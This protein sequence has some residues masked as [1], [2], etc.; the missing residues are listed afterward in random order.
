[1]TPLVW[2]ELTSWHESTKMEWVV[3]W[4]L[5][6]VVVVW[7]R[8]WQKKTQV[9]SYEEI[10]SHILSHAATKKELSE[11]NGKID[12]AIIGS[13]V[14]ALV[15]AALLT[16]CGYRVA[17]FEQHSVVGGSTHVYHKA[18]FDFDVGVHYV[19]NQMDRWHSAFRV[20][21][22]LVSDSQLEWCR[23]A[24]TYDVAYN[25]KTGER[26]EFTGDP[27]HNRNTILNNFPDIDPR[28]L[29]EYYRRCKQARILANIALF[30]LK[31]LPRCV[32][33]LV[34]SLGYGSLYNKLCTRKT[35][36]VLRACGLPDDVIGAITYSWGDYGTPPGQSPFFIQAFMENHYDGGAFFPKGGSTSIAK[37][38]VAAIKRRGG[39]VFAA[40]PVDSIITR[41]NWRGNHV[42]V[43]IIAR[44]VEIRVRKAV[45]SNAGFGRTFEV[46]MYGNP[47]L[48]SQVA[49]AQQL[50]CVHKKEATVPFK[51]SPA[52]WY[53]FVGLDGTDQE[54]ELLGQNVWHLKHWDHDKAMEE[55]L[56]GN[57]AREGVDAEPALV[58]LS[59]ESAKDPDYQKNHPG[60]STAVMIAW[61]SPEWFR[62]W[63]KKPAGQ[64]GNDYN[65]LKSDMTN[66]LL[67]I[68]Y[69]H[70]PLTKG[71]VT[72][73]DIGSPL[74][75]SRFLGRNAG[76]IYN[77]DHNA[78][79][80]ET[81]DAQLALHPETTISGL[82]LTGQD[83]VAVSICG[84][85]M[86]GLATASRVSG[87]AFLVFCL[88][89][90]SGYLVWST[91]LA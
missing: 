82:F 1:M 26:L 91:L 12:I 78:S 6:V 21:F 36:D 80:F 28:T 13:G 32:T 14:G 24:E 34:W 35:I 66:K 77:L 62:E 88:P 58:F 65:K 59:N 16:R 25:G 29:D 18:G 41:R 2:K 81:L 70:F 56:S 8:M 40:T 27:K 38:I 50:G 54:L 15:S 67:Q 46:D 17:V 86:S 51:P 79:R 49:G 33:R 3:L 75:A 4:S 47:P 9:P 48:V 69:L 44:G 87:L 72:F 11:L 60:K 71:R 53:L 68:L 90:V 83:T 63:N 52:F 5:A 30:A 7:S 39:G 10:P 42:A 23:I 37:T 73:A 74:T 22:D 19:G 45:I 84:A 85:A 64:R 43:G 57:T 89:L 76:E 55:L 61:T 31:C 20:L